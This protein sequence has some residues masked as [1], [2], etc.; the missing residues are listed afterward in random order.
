G[1]PGTHPSLRVLL[2]EDD[3]TNQDAMRTY[4]EGLGHT[5]TSANSAPEALAQTDAFD[6]AL[7]DFNLGEGQDGLDVIAHLAKSHPHARFALITAS[8]EADIEERALAL[9]AAYFRKPVVPNDLAAWLHQG[10]VL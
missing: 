2:V 10:A 6:V 9:D 7:I 5:C 4:L 3:L 1:V 8:P